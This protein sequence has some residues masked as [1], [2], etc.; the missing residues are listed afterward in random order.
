MQEKWKKLIREKR[1]FYLNENK[2]LRMINIG[3]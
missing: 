3:E 2:K 1:L